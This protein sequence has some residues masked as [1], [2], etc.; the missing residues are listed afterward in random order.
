MAAVSLKYRLMNCSFA[1][2][3][4]RPWRRRLRPTNFHRTAS[5]RQQRRQV[6]RRRGRCSVKLEDDGLF[7]ACSAIQVASAPSPA[8]SSYQQV[9]IRSKRV[10]I[11]LCRTDKSRLKQTQSAT[12]RCWL[13]RHGQ[14]Q[15][16][17]CSQVRRCHRLLDL[18][19]HPR[20][21]GAATGAAL[22]NPSTRAPK[23]FRTLCP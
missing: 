16:L 23:S 3:G 21:L 7:S 9:G 5:R 22:R 2:D 8:S 19:D 13:R 15:Q 18:H 14:P 1:R 10:M 20:T 11:S 12:P 6:W 17:K 4:S